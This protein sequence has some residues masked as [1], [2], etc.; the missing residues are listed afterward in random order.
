MIKKHILTD[1]RLVKHTYRK[2]TTFHCCN[3]NQKS[4]NLKF[5]KENRFENIL[6]VIVFFFYIF[7]SLVLIFSFKKNGNIVAFILIF[8]IL[9]LMLLSFINLY[10]KYICKKFSLVK[11]DEKYIQIIN[12][13]NLFVKMTEINKKTIKRLCEVSNFV[14]KQTDTLCSVTLIDFNCSENE[15]TVFIKFFQINK[16]VDLIEGETYEFYTETND[17]VGKICVIEKY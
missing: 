1:F 7:I 9:T 14:I 8:G 15:A 10:E 16:D 12:K 3:C 6:P 11:C 17:M 4:I 5:E 13:P 2:H